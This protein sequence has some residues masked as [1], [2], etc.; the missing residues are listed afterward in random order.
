M[1]GELVLEARG[2]TTGLRVIPAEGQGLKVESSFQERGKILGQDYNMIGTYLSF[3]RPDGFLYGEGQGILT[4][5]QGDT[6]TFAGQGIGKRRGSGVS[7]RAALYF[8]TASKNLS[9]LNGIAVILEYE[10]DAEGNTQ[11]KG[12]EWK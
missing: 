9:R 5:D 7:W 6:A 4:T 12:W 1:Q 2:K 8:Q 10:V 11:D 3:V